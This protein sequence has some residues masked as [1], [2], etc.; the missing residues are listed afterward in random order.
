MPEY[1]GTGRR[2]LDRGEVE[3][4]NDSVLDERE[5]EGGGRLGQWEYGQSTVRK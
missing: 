3:D 1:H 4:G 5:Q 2:R